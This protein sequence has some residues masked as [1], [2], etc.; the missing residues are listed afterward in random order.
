MAAQMGK[1]PSTNH[2]QSLSEVVGPSLNKITR[3][4]LTEARMR[5]FER[6]TAATT[7]EEAIMQGGGGGS[8]TYRRPSRRSGSR[9]PTTKLHHNQLMMNSSNS[10]QPPM[11]QFEQRPPNT[12]GLSNGGINSIR[13]EQDLEDSG[14]YG[15]TPSKH[16]GTL[17]A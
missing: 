9:S 12:S 8:Q 16:E 3:N 4:Q 13:E 1:P 5:S 7:G 17:K 10:E 2:Q 11:M 14:A 15:T 6:P